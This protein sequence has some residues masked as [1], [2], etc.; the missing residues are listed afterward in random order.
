MIKLWPDVKQTLQTQLTI[1]LMVI[2]I[3]ST[4]ISS[5]VFSIYEY[6]NADSADTLRLESIADILA[7]NLTASLVFDDKTT[8]SELIQ[9]LNDQSNIVEVKVYNADGEIYVAQTNSTSEVS[10]QPKLKRIAAPLFVDGTYYGKLVIHADSSLIDKH[11]NFFISFISIILVITLIISFG[12][13]VAVSRQFTNPI[14]QLAITANRVTKSNNY[15]LRAENNSQDEIGDLTRCFNVMLETIEHRD[16][17]LEWKVSQRTNQLKI[18]NTKLK[19]QAYK[20]SLCGLPNRRYL[21]ESM[22]ELVSEP[23]GH[24]F[25]LMFIDL[26]GFKEV[27]DTMG[28]DAGDML[29]VSA[30]SR[31]KQN[32][33]SNDI[34]ARLG[35]DEFT[36]LVDGISDKDKISNIAE[37][38]RSALAMPFQV[39]GEDVSITASIGICSFPSCGTTVEAIMKK[40]DLAMYAAKDDGRN[41]Y[42]FFEQ[43]ML[44]RMQLKRRMLY[45]LRTAI[46][47]N[48]FELYY[49]PII[50]IRTGKIEKA[51]ALIRWNHPEKGLISP[52]QFIP[53]AENNGLINDI[54]CWITGQAIAAVKRFRDIYNPSFTVAINASPVQFRKDSPWFHDLVNKMKKADLGNHAISI[55]ITENTL[56]GNDQSVLDKLFALNDMGIE[57]AID[58]FG[59]GYSSLSY[60]QKLSVDIIK[61]DRSFVSQLS[62]DIASNTLC[63]TMV[64][65]ANN[66]NMKVVAEGV[67][68][69]EQLGLLNQYGCHYAQ[70]YLFSK[71]IKIEL[72]EELLSSYNQFN[73]PLLVRQL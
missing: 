1:R 39:L 21:L 49:Q 36:V 66:L 65:M 2:A 28:H 8:A 47:N 10:N 61:I 50:N 71:P 43:P 17:T 19:D 60:L 29:I 24:T 70:G 26:D 45:D 9:P 27:N 53:H 48:E 41:C 25:T 23:H 5:L 56:I 20:D 44:D 42:R 55:E 63:K 67:E 54:G 18:A 14:S 4:T 32:I 64:S 40:A 30:A 38:T 7:P 72:F 46:E 69:Y 58:D 59:V 51:E 68:E 31:I 16:Q 15:S 3:M 62:K 11:V 34:L 57:I 12:V 52:D 6:N 33:S 35:G 37:K 73:T 22:S 13:S